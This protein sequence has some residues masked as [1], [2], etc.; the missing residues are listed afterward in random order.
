[1]K[2]VDTNFNNYITP[3]MLEYSVVIYKHT[4]QMLADPCVWG[5][6]NLGA[7]SVT[8]GGGT[9]LDT[10]EKIM[11]E[12]NVLLKTCKYLNFVEN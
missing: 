4:I 8:C 2:L 10:R 7:C 3:D 6:W 1:M 11:I 5:Q 9:R 12:T